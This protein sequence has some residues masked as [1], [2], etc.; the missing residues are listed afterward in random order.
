MIIRRTNRWL[1]RN[2]L[3]R[4]YHHRARNAIPPLKN[5]QRR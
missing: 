4:Y 1:R 3:A 2:E 5:E